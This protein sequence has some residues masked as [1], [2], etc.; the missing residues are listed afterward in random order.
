MGCGEAPLLSGHI[1]AYSSRARSGVV[2]FPA[3]TVKTRC[4]KKWPSEGMVPHQNRPPAPVPNQYLI[5]G[6]LH[7]L[8]T[9]GKNS[10]TR[11]TH[12]HAENRKKCSK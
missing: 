5:V 12:M 2:C 6:I 7:Y 8:H 11:K 4:N 3:P 9:L 10:L 1:Q